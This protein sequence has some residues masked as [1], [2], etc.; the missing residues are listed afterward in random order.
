MTTKIP[1]AVAN[2]AT[3]AEAEA[4][5]ATDKFM[6]PER[7]Q[8]AIAAL[9]SWVLASQVEA[10]AG[11]ENTKAMTALRTKQAIDAM[12]VFTESYTSADQTI[13]AAG[14]LTLAHGLSAT[15]SL[16]TAKL[17]CTSAEHNYAVNDEVIIP[18]GSTNENNGRGAAVIA[19]GT[20]LNV[21]F[22]SNATTFQVL[23]KTTGAAANITNANW[24]IIF[25][26]WA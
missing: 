26:A 3:Q 9:E 24:D 18:V 13:T 8:Q 14:S 10:E 23:N 19:D 15:P 25:F 7:T 5:T 12:S 2:V 22:G 16:V 11:T 4:G 17:K 6:T 20:N 1:P 21:R